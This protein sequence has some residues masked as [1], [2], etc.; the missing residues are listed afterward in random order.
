MDFDKNIDQLYEWGLPRYDTYPVLKGLQYSF[1][2]ESEYVEPVTV[3]E[4]KDH[5]YI[6]AD[7]DDNL[8]ELYLKAARINVENYLQKSLGIRT[9]TLLAQRLPKDYRLPWGPVETVSTSGFTLFGDILIEGG[10][11][12]TVEYVTNASLVNDSIKTAIYKRA[13]DYYENRGSS[14]PMPDIVKMIL[15]PYRR[16]VFP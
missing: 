7:T 5:A 14:G 1:T 12:V 15:N 4:F 13:F 2:D 8:L 10:E 6:D 3:E 11:N 16:V 9:I